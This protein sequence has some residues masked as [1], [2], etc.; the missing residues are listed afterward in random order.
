MKHLYLWMILLI[1]SSC[2]SEE[3]LTTQTSQTHQFSKSMAGYPENKANAFDSAGKLHNELCLA[4]EMA[5]SPILS[6]GDAIDLTESL[7]LANASMVQL[8][9]GGFIPLSE[10]RLEFILAD[11]LQALQVI[12]QST[13]S[14]KAKI[15]LA[16]FLSVL[17]LYKSQEKQYAQIYDFIVNYE[18]SIT[19]DLTFS[20][21]DKQILFTTTSIARYAHHFASLR[22]KKPPR[23]KDWDIKT[24]SILSGTDGSRQNTTAAIRMSVAASLYV[25]R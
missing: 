14:L 3:D 16:N 9:P 25:N 22:K 13:L 11:S 8:T 17:E 2:H 19:Q 15:S 23:D 10:S 12:E 4:Y 18:D 6:M 5:P 21:A 20:S 24:A 1:L 7:S